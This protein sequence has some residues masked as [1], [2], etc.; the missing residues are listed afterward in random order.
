MS[1]YYCNIFQHFKI[2]C[3]YMEPTNSLLIRMNANQNTTSFLNM[4]GISKFSHRKNTQHK[5][6]TYTQATWT[7]ICSF[8]NWTVQFQP[9]RELEFFSNAAYCSNELNNNFFRATCL[10]AWVSQCTHVCS[11][12][13]PCLTLRDPMD[14]SLPGSSV[15]GIFQARTWSGLPPPTPKDL[16]DPGIIPASPALA[17]GL[18]PSVP[19]AIPS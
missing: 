16:P 2:K 1:Q 13:Q 15:H 4:Q 8:G 6:P 11:W 9:N 18:P 5:K 19:L 17:G 7:T 12:A 10:A 14:C 3:S